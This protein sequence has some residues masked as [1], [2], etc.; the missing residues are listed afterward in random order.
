MNN[1]FWGKETFHIFVHFRFI[2]VFSGEK[3]GPKKGEQGELKRE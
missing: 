1:F 2:S 3:N